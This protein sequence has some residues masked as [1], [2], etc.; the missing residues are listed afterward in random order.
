[1]VKSDAMFFSRVNCQYSHVEESM[2]VHS[3]QQIDKSIVNCTCSIFII[4]NLE[5]YVGLRF[6]LKSGLDNYNN[7]LLWV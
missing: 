7:N 1:M 6:H 2:P 5:Y 4:D 3:L